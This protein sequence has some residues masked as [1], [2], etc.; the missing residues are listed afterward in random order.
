MQLN[1]SY[2]IT[3]TGRNTGSGF[4]TRNQS[5]ERPHERARR[6]DR[7]ADLELA[8][9]RH[10]AAERLSRAAAELREVAP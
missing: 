2:T 3:P 9:S 6:L 10:S 4:L 8:H 5:A 1:Y 7:L